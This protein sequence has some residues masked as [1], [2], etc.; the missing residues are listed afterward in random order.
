MQPMVIAGQ[1]GEELA[2]LKE[3]SEVTFAAEIAPPRFVCFV[4]LYI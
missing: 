3:Q 4:L 1:T 2:W